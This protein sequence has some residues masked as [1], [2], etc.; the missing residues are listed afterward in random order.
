MREEIGEWV[1]SNLNRVPTTLADEEVSHI[2]DCLE[3][4]QQWYDLDW[5]LGHFLTAVVRDRFV[6]ACCLADDTNSKALILYALYVHNKLP[7]N[8]KDKL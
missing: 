8:Y 4:I 5:P 2:V 1:T 3:A 7:A 6:D